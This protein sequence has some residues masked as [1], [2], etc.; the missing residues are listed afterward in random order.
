MPLYHPAFWPETLKDWVELIV[1]VIGI[2]TAVVS[3]F[4]YYRNSKEARAKWLS[5]MY[6]RYYG[7]P[8][9]RIVRPFM[10]GS[11]AGLKCLASP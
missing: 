7:N 1:A 9:M 11:C 8:D 4:T 3:A 2:V 6:H 10:P 5:E